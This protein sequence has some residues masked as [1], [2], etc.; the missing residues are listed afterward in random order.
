MSVYQKPNKYRDMTDAQRVTYHKQQG[1]AL[2]HKHDLKIL[3]FLIDQH[4]ELLQICM[5]HVRELGYAVPDSVPKHPGGL[6]TCKVE[7]KA[8]SGKDNAAQSKD[9]VA[10]EQPQ[11]SL[12]RLRRRSGIIDENPKNWIQ[13]CFTSLAGSAT[14][15]VFLEGILKELFP[16]RF[17]EFHFKVLR[18]SLKDMAKQQGADDV[19][20]YK[21]CLVQ[22]VHFTTGVDCWTNLVGD[23]RH[24]PTLM[25][26][27]ADG[28]AARPGFIHEVALPLDWNAHGVYKLVATDSALF[29]S[30]KLF[31]ESDALDVTNYVQEQLGASPAELQELYL[32]DNF[33]EHRAVLG[34]QESGKSVS[35]L[36]IL[37][38]SAK[39]QG[40]YLAHPV[41]PPEPEKC[42]YETPCKRAKTE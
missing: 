17:S 7:V 23:M 16:T 33:G 25:K 41:S 11:G 3:N 1:E 27:L 38:E 37:F 9:Q 36:H 18:N 42:E 13:H 35:N 32:G 12:S 20:K 8:E 6:S 31:P 29:L 34:H 30:S 5:N 40:V 2:K 22:A 4:K 15:A 24:R 39:V 19:P 14:T 21:D 28:V 26:H 10:G